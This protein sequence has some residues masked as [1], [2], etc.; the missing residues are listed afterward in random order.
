MTAFAPLPLGANRKTGIEI[1]FGGLSESHAAAI[2]RDTLGGRLERRSD[3]ELRLSGSALGEI[4]IFLDTALRDSLKGP[5]AKFGLDV[6]RAVIPVE[7]VTPPL[8]A[9]QLPQADRLCAALRARGAAGTAHGLTLGFGLHLNPEVPSERIADLM[10][11]ITAYAVLEDLLRYEGGMDLTRRLLPFAD[12][13]PRALVDAL[14]GAHTWSRD[15]LFDVYLTH[16]RSRNHG[17]DLLPLLAHLDGDRVAR[18]LGATATAARP[19]WHY[20]LPD[21][22]IDEARWSVAREWNRWVMVERVAADA[23]L[24]DRLRADWQDYRAALTT[25][26]PDWRACLHDRLAEYG[27]EVAP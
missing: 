18:A 21:C 5:V 22:R 7:I 16:V 3:H 2:A 17:L 1:E 14:T 25:T 13:W 12:P 27:H 23:G 9:R 4:E 10:P 26:R 15:M 6:S 24:L 11:T 19:A 8:A 20:R